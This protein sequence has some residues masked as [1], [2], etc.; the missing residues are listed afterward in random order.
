MRAGHVLDGRGDGHQRQ[1][2]RQRGDRGHALMTVQAPVLIRLHLFHV[3]G[4]L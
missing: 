4:R 1:A 3:I 2:R